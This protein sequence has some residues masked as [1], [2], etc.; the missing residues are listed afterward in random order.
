MNE[1]AIEKIVEWGME[2]LDQ[3]LRDHSRETCPQCGE[4]M[5]EG[6]CR[7]FTQERL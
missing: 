7:C 4:Q 2:Q 3:E 5:K 6:L 1:F